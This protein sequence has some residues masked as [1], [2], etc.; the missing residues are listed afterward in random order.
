MTR[1][2]DCGSTRT[3]D[4]CPACGLTSA[5][6][7]VMFRRR[8]FKQTVIFL[9]GSLAFPYVIQVYPPLDI[10]PM[11]VFFGLLFF[12]SLTLVVLLDRR[13]R[14]HKEV[15]LLKRIFYGL[16]PLPWIF[17][18]IIFCNGRLDSAKDIEYHQTTI[19][20]R[21][22]MR[23]VVRGSRRLYV[24][25]WREGHSIERLATDTDDFDRFRDGDRVVV[26]TEPGALEIPWYYGV[27]RQ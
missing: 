19:V 26:A 25:S 10:D 18:A 4:Q 13:A 9:T 23:G 5:A 12:V 14:A 24:R 21:F 20:G 27:Y 7:E 16:V 2:P 17:T 22:Y 15:D 1:C 6:A 11:L 3:T 8:L